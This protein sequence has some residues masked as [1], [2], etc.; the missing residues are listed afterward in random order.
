MTRIYVKPTEDNSVPDPRRNDLL[1][2]E[3]RSVTWTTYW[4][5]RLDAQE[6]V[7]CDQPAPPAPEKPARGKPSTP[8]AGSASA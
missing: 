6:V 7:E 3:G 2:A 4:Q 8:D 5:R 1:P